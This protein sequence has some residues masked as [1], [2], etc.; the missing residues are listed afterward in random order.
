MTDKAFYHVVP[1][2][3]QLLPA[4]RHA[5]IDCNT[6]MAFGLSSLPNTLWLGSETFLKGYHHIISEHA[7]TVTDLSD[8]AVSY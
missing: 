6:N 4:L 8:N 2:S 1:L 7:F 5:W 3:Q